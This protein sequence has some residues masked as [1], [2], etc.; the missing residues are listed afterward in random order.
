MDT[1]V[2]R[3]AREDDNTQIHREGIYISQIKAQQQLKI[4]SMANFVPKRA[5]TENKL[6]RKSPAKGKD[7]LSHFMKINF[8]RDLL[9]PFFSLRDLM[10]IRTLSKSLGRNVAPIIHKRSKQ[11]GIEANCYKEFKKKDVLVFGVQPDASYIGIDPMRTTILIISAEKKRTRIIGRFS[12]MKNLVIFDI[13]YSK[14][15]QP[16]E[17]IDFKIW[18]T[19]K[20]L[21]HEIGIPNVSIILQRS[22]VRGDD[23][24]YQH[25]PHWLE[26]EGEGEDDNLRK[27]FN[28]FK[29]KL[30]WFFMYLYIRPCQQRSAYGP[31]GRGRFIHDGD[32]KD[33]VK[34]LINTFMRKPV[35]FAPRHHGFSIFPNRVK[36]INEVDVVPMEDSG[37]VNLY[38]NFL[39][40]FATKGLVNA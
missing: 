1:H 3:L 14:N 18:R 21:Q 35:Q 38:I 31:I 29:I 9:V 4:S 27:I 19:Q 32:V 13:P 39:G 36:K 33:D 5:K 8:F 2:S 26:D 24:Y 17:Y 6:E 15:K 34:T 23:V 22:I 16:F 11:I 12:E 30:K 40:Y 25:F 37:F 28:I 20:T 7:C 10:R